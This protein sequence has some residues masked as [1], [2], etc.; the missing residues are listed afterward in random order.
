MSH[1]DHFF[2][3]LFEVFVLDRYLLKIRSMLNMS[4]NI[5]PR[6]AQLLD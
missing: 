5:F 2:P 4:S 3:G 1:F 6:N